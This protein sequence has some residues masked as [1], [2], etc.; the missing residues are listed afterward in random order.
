MGSLPKEAEF[1]DSLISLF[2]KYIFLS[3]SFR[4]F[5]Y[6]RK[7]ESLVTSKMGIFLHFV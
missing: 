7:K 6:Q 5:N 2:F 4:F 1:Q 3:F